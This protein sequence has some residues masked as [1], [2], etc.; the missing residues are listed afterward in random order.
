MRGP[1][2]NLC[3]YLLIGVLSPGAASAEPLDAPDFDREI[4]PLIARRCLSC[5]SGSEPKGRLDLSSREQA[6]AGG[7]SG[8]VIEPGDPAKS[9]LWEHIDSDEMPPKKPLS[10]AEKARIKAWIAAGATW[11][12]DKIDPFRF[13]TDARGGFDWWSLKPLG[14][15]EL[16]RIEHSGW[17]ANPIDAFVLARLSE[18]GLAPSAAADKRTLIRRLSFDLLGLPPTPAQIDAF[19]ADSSEHA[20][21]KLVER[22]LDSPHY[23]ERWARHWLDIVCF[24]ESN[25]FEYDEPRENFWHYRNWIIGALNRDMPYDEFVRL[26]LAGDVLYPDDVDAAAATG[27][28]VAGPHNTTLPANDAMRMTMAQD[29]LEDLVGIV[30]Q[31]FLGLTV[32]CARCH[33]HKFDPISQ[34]EYYQLAAALAGVKHGERI[35]QVPLLPQ[36]KLRIIE[37]DARLVEIHRQLDAIAQP[38]RDAILTELKQAAESGP[39]PPQ[40][41]AIW[42]FDGDL[43]D[44]HGVLDGKANGGARVENG[45]LVLDGKKA[46]VETSPLAL[47]LAEKT[48]EAWVELS[49]LDQRGGAVIGVQSLDGATFDAIV[50]GE[51][52]PKKWLAGSNNFARTKPLNGAEETDAGKRPVHIALVY[53]KDGTIAGYR[54]GQPYGQPYRS[55]EL[56]HFAARG[57]QVLIGLR[58][59]PAKENKLLSGRIQRAQLYNRALSPHEIA[60]SAAAG[61]RNF[62]TSAQILERLPLE[63]RERHG[64]LN[65]EILSLQTEKNSLTDMAAP[66]LYSCVPTEA[67]VTRVLRRGNVADPAEE[68]SP[69]GLR[70]V[71]GRESDF[72]LAPNAKDAERRKKLAEW[73]THGGNALFAR[74]MVNRLW[75]YH[76]GQGIVSTPSDLG[77]NGGKP[78]HPELLDW[79]AEQFRSGGY[80][81]KPMHRLIVT[82]AAYRQ[83]SDLNRDATKIDADNRWLWRK[84]PQRL[85]A[86][87]IRDAVLVTTG[88]LDTELGGRGYRDVRHFPFKGSNFYEPLIEAGSEAR[89]R[90]IYR[91]SP[92]GGRNPFLDTFDCPD[93]SATAPKRVATTTPLQTLALM[94]NALIFEMADNFAQRVTLEAG[95]STGKQIELVYLRAYGRGAQEDEV[96][97]ASQFVDQHGLPSFCRVI[98]NS[99]EFLYV[100]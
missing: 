30:G 89:R 48:L 83:S 96:Q 12:T 60:A 79:L 65:A 49:N 37:I 27:F 19:L 61:D 69:A 14:N 6:M 51:R 95:P 35:V 76:F 53:Q 88:Q 86:E 52:E 74:V 64:Q 32:N 15:P 8:K 10:A 62:V 94:N 40:A 9:K 78:S 63:Q 3:L 56:Q 22:L 41:L 16:P 34:K 21:D 71:V 66:K 58:H 31:T 98:L 73:I 54:D 7:E 47:D 67:G 28:L 90:T 50:F 75:H 13:T 24:G 77:Y 17:N 43:R 1:F 23:G 4:A 59:S 44:S 100:R 36:Q 84:S 80:R 29:E 38:I 11:G 85:E 70:A 20:Y 2:P 5:H 91:F 99:N 72:G 42:E 46:Y 55:G 25:G 68:V 81:L 45:Y 87:A 57:F 33:D 97:L 92:R 39:E 18:A 82:S 26:Q 93:P